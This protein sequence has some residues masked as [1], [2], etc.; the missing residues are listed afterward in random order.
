MKVIERCS[1]CPR[2]C[3]TACPVATGA[4]REA[5]VPAQIASAVLAWRQ[6][7]L[8][9]EAVRDA[10][11]SCVD[12]GACQDLCHLHV[13]LPEALSTLRRE[14]GTAP[15]P[16]KLVDP[17]PGAVLLVVTRDEESLLP[18][19]QE[20]VAAA[21]GEQVGRWRA[22]ENLGEGS[23]EHRAARRHLDDVR[24]MAGGR[25]VVT[26]HRGVSRVLG[27]AGVRCVELWDLVGLTPPVG[28]GDPA[29]PIACCGGRRPFARQHEQDAARMAR[30]WVAREGPCS[31]LDS[32]CAA[33][34][35]GAG[36]Q[37]T[38]LVEAWLEE[39]AT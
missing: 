33:H 10:V 31:G 7:R 19:Y 21:I 2:L 25:R 4:A 32:R 37:A 18:R 6:G 34:L 23:L 11:T 9:S 35:R 30:H 8:P 27:L 22:P 29:A 14:L 24:A 12:C 38:S 3:R 28:C 20:A 39:V 26:A 5:A 13:P 36:A 1:L 15:P 16:P 17:E